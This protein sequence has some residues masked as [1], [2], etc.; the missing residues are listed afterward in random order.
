[1]KWRKVQNQWGEMNGNIP[2]TLVACKWYLQFLTANKFDE[3]IVP[4]WAEG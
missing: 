4:E 1:M 2:Y 3:T